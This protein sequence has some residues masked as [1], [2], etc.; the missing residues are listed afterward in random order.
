MA[1][2]YAGFLPLTAYTIHYKIF[3]PKEKEASGTPN[4]FPIYLQRPRQKNGSYRVP[5]DEIAAAALPGLSGM[6]SLSGYIPPRMVALH[7]YRFLTD[8]FCNDT[9]ARKQPTFY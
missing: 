3:S 8:H 1:H 5:V 9:A 6:P 7:H 2:Q 4:L